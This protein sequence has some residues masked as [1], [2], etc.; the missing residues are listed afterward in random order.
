MNW[1][2]FTSRKDLHPQHQDVWRTQPTRRV[3][4]PA[5]AA[6]DP[7]RSSSR[8]RPCLTDPGCFPLRVIEGTTVN[9]TSQWGERVD[10]SEPERLDDQPGTLQSS[11]ISSA[12]LDPLMPSLS[13]FCAVEKP[14]IPLIETEK[15]SNE[16]RGTESSLSI[17]SLPDVGLHVP[18]PQW[19]LWCLSDRPLGPSLHKQWG[20]RRPARLW[21]RTCFRSGR[22]SRLQNK[23]HRSTSEVIW[24]TSAFSLFASCLLVHLRTLVNL[25]GKL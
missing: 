9:R 21:S 12:V 2:N 14:G 18:F 5:P 4:P 3:R 25:R 24:V 8:T 16:E 1:L 13:S 20:R 7:S 11:K 22:S 19:K 15:D 10:A 23:K 6:P 17:K